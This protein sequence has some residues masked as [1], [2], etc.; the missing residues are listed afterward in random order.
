MK[1][2]FLLSLLVLLITVPLFFACDP[3]M[4][5]M[6]TSDDFLAP[7]FYQD[8]STP[9]ALEHPEANNMGRLFES[10]YL[11]TAPAIVGLKKDTEHKAGDSFKA[12]YLGTELTIATSKS[13]TVTDYTISDSDHSVLISISYDSSTRKMDYHQKSV[14]HTSPENMMY[15]SAEGYDVVEIKMN[16]AAVGSDLSLQPRYDLICYRKSMDGTCS[17]MAADN[18]EFYSKGD[19]YGFVYNDK[20]EFNGSDFRPGTEIPTTA[21]FDTISAACKEQLTGSG[22]EINENFALWYDAGQIGGS[23]GTLSSHTTEAAIEAALPWTTALEWSC[24]Y[25][26]T[27]DPKNTSPTTKTPGIAKG[28][29]LTEPTAPENAGYNFAGWFTDDACTDKWDFASDTIASNMTLYAKWTTLAVFTVYFDTDGGSSLS[30]L[31]DIAEG[32]TIAEPAAPTKS[33]FTFAGWFHDPGL[34]TAWNFTSDT[35]TSD[36]TLYAKWDSAELDVY[37]AGL[38]VNSE[39]NGVIAYWKNSSMV[40]LASYV[41]EGDTAT[42]IFVQNNDVYVAGILNNKAVYWKNGTKTE[43]PDNGFGA[44]A[45]A[46]TVVGED[47]YV[48]GA[49]GTDSGSVAA[50][51]KKE[52]LTEL[53]GGDT[54]TAI[55]VDGGTVYTAGFDFNDG[56]NFIAKYWTNSTPTVLT[57]GNTPASVS[58]IC[59]VG[60]YVYT[61]GYENDGTNDIAKYWINGIEQPTLSTTSS[62]AFQIVKDDSGIYISGWEQDGTNYKGLYWKD[63]EAVT[64]STNISISQETSIAVNNGDVYFLCTESPNNIKYWKNGA[65]H[66]VDTGWGMD[67]TVAP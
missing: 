35:V 52:T 19:I 54:L 43:L 11:R 36:K 34:T 53:T 62:R 20:K 14:I 58:S 50:Y 15:Q 2:K 56:S 8:L 16:G 7:V 23:A 44:S 6:E 60:T 5:P 29:K 26:L 67:M 59:V 25:T 1:H 30:P 65:E 57:Y 3:E 39:G 66:I 45:K 48:A 41:A 46:I 37:I 21:N 51:W 49:V 17:L 42:S 22:T 10:G 38:G 31:T 64:L 24:R 55:T 4:P 18:I 47:V 27:L 12:S 40:E 9:K 28:S 13:G 63:G 32:S 61:A 33:G